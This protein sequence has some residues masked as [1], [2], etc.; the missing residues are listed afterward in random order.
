M[1][2]P[3]PT[4]F[5][6]NTSLSSL[7]FITLQWNI[8]FDLVPPTIFLLEYNLTKLSG[9][10]T[11]ETQFNLSLNAADTMFGSS[12][13]YNVADPLSFTQYEFQL[14]AVYEG[15]QS[16]GVSTSYQTPE[17]SEFVSISVVYFVGRGGSQL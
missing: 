4:N 17:T 16:N 11:N 13:S 6:V 2:A 8:P 15:D 9:Q 5:L 1:F 7:T 10:P 14:F 3:A 12:Y